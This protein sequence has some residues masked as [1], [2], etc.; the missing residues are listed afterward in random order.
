MNETLIIP[1]YN[2]QKIKFDNNTTVLLDFSIQPLTDIGGGKWIEIGKVQYTTDENDGT[3]AELGKNTTITMDDSTIIVGGMDYTIDLWFFVYKIVNS[4][5]HL[6]D[7]SI[8]GSN[9]RFCTDIVY[10]NT[11]SNMVSST[12]II[13][14]GTFELNKV[15]H[16]AEVCEYNKKTVKYYLDGINIASRNNYQ[17]PKKT[18]TNRFELGG[19]RYYGDR[20]RNFY[21]KIANFRVSQGIARWTANFDI[22]SIYN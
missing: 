5:T 13:T 19:D 14:L 8:D 18:Y 2:S 20:E 11:L 21:G 12:N 16:F 4:T 9:N 22:N 15:H 7:M 10:P 17:R 6:Y 3:W 1:N